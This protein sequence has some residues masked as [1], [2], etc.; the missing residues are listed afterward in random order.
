MLVYADLRKN[1]S[2]PAIDHPMVVPCFVT[3]A[4]VAVWLL[5]RNSFPP[6]SLKQEI[7]IFF[8]SLITA[9]V[10]LIVSI[11]VIIHLHLSLGETL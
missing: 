5:S 2:V 1:W 6:Q 7:I 9:G 4:L 3:L 10:W 11:V 8:L